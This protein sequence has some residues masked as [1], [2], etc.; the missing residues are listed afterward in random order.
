MLPKVKS[1]SLI[2]DLLMRSV[3]FAFLLYIVLRARLIPITIDEVSTVLNHVP[4]SVMD[5]ITYKNDATPNNHVLNTLLIKAFSWILGD[6]HVVV[7]IPAMLGGAIYGWVA[8]RLARMHSAAG[9][10]WF[11]F[12]MLM[13]NPF[14]LEFFSLARGYSLGAGLMLAAIYMAVLYDSTRKVR[15]LA[16]SILL[17]MLAVESNFTLLNFF[18][19]FV[20]L[21]LWWRWSNQRIGFWPAL[22]LVA[23]GTGI[24]GALCYL[25]IMGMRSTDQFHFWGASGF[26]TET[27]IPLVK[28]SIRNGGVLGAETVLPVAWAVVVFSIGAWITGIVYWI[29]QKGIMD[30][31]IWITGLFFGTVLFNLLQFYIFATPF[32][33][34]RTALFFYP[35]FALQMAVVAQW[36]WDRWGKW[37]LAYI[38][39]VLLLTGINFKECVNLSNSYEW[40][41]DSGT[42]KVLGYLQKQYTDENRTEPFTLDA[43]W[44]LIN[45]VMYHTNH[46]TPHFERFVKFPGWH[47]DRPYLKDTEFYYTSARE[48]VIALESEYEVVMEIPGAITWLLRKKR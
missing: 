20:F 28:S 23:G 4:R 9:I 35:L 32:L 18:V 11:V 39:P 16:G 15:D 19:P 31:K 37:T 12:L 44:E 47:G 30:A 14:V 3:L 22:L 10:R 40:W 38:L 36:K 21:L 29:R 24:L 33:N 41:F 26:F 2:E 17:A 45:S 48:E 43:R 13:G 8:Y 6:Y 5:I 46:S 34:A 7:R 27:V 25:P 42:L 1:F